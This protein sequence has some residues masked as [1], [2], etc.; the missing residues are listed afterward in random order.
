[1]YK[2]KN[3][4]FL[5][6]NTPIFKKISIPTYLKKISKH[7]MNF[8]SLEYFIRRLLLLNDH[9]KLL[10]IR[11]F[12]F[13][14]LIDDYGKLFILKMYKLYEKKKYSMV[15]IIKKNSQKVDCVIFNNIPKDKLYIY[16]LITRILDD[17]IF[18]ITIEEKYVLGSII[19]SENYGLDNSYLSYFYYYIRYIIYSSQDFNDRIYKDNRVN[20]E[21]N[22]KYLKKYWKELIKTNPHYV[23]DMKKIFDINYNSI[24]EKIDNFTKTNEYNNVKK[25]IKIVP[26]KF[27]LKKSFGIDKQLQYKYFSQLL[28]EFKLSKEYNDL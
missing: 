12:T 26:F 27:P 28:E 22:E 10:Y 25:Q 1:M 21:N 11:N 16:I 20:G 9:I 14:N 7:S 2:I 15:K 5:I 23:S 3:Y 24:M 4:D 18:P 6:K 13:I 19:T 17:Y 8:T